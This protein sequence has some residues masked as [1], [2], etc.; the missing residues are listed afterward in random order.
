VHPIARNGH[1]VYVSRRHVGKIGLRLAGIASREKLLAQLVSSVQRD[2][3][4]RSGHFP[5]DRIARCLSDW[6][7]WLC[8]LKRRKQHANHATLRI[9]SVVDPPTCAIKREFHDTCG[10]LKFHATDLAEIVHAKQTLI[11]VET[12]FGL[13]PPPRE[14]RSYRQHCQDI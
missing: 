7:C 2:F 6:S 13:H 10:G 3:H 5:T 8:L 1:Y 14:Q 9:V 4:A 11:N 12:V